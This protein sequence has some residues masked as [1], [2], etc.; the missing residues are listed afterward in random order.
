MALVKMKDLLNHAYHNRYAV[1]AFEIVSL[2][3]LRA[4]IEAAETSRSP[5]ILNVVEAHFDLFDIE[6]LM[7]AVAHAAKRAS[8]PVAIHMDH[9]TSLD[10]IRRAIALGSNSVMFD[11]SQ[12]DFPVNTEKTRR[13]VELAHSCGVPVEG[14]LGYVAGISGDDGHA[15]EDSSVYTSV[16]EAKAYV[17][18]TGIDFLAISIGT[19]HGRTNGKMRF[20]SGL[21]MRIKESVNIPF[22]I[23]GGS[24]LSG[25]QYHKLIDHGVAKI[26]YFT[27]LS[28][29]AINQIR[30][31][32]AR[33]CDSYRE[34]FAHIKDALVK[35]VQNCMQVWRS[36]GRAAEV[37]MQCG[38]WQNIEHVIVYNTSSNDLQL[39]E[40]MMRK[41][42]QQL[43]SIPGVMRVQVGRA[44]DERGS[45]RYC[46][47]I[48]FAGAEV[49]EN[50][51]THPVHVEYADSFFRPLA[52]DRITADYEMLDDLELH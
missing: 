21:L 51:K 41:G 26:N 46:W 22:V 5:V 4:V 19:V 25:Q 45:Y 10:S 6:Q 39:I 29:L 44:V 17:E 27:A 36:A 48:R 32:F 47:L 11:A 12:T 52:A 40:R 24:G 49:I 43:S 16:P 7:A 15:A 13:A 31:N 9:C 37:L 42:K 50:Y 20:D 3:F 8:V 28:E 14:E 38:A 2:D 23:H 33:D 34:A 18:R 35:E 30:T 1:G